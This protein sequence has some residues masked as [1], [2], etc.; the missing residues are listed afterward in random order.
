[1]GAAPAFVFLIAALLWLAV[2]PH[3]PFHEYVNLSSSANA[4]KWNLYGGRWS[5]TAD[6]I[7]NLTGN[8]GDKAIYGKEQWTD[9]SI[10]S[11][12]RFDTDPRGMHWGDAGFVARVASPAIGVDAYHGYYA[13]ISFEDQQVFI[14]KAD[15]SWNR[16]TAAHLA[17]PVALA[18]WYHL[19]VLVKGCYI[20]VRASQVSKKGTTKASFY[21]EGCSE[22][23]G[24]AGIRTFGVR[25]SWRNLQISPL[26]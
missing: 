4:A 15:Y 8:R 24:A 6:G 20:E 23:S 7:Q 17:Q 1:M 5:F 19:K 12:L 2:R 25:A 9:Y 22:K 10:D 11:D 21:D 26:P 16:L 3:R 14:G 13:G 18:Q